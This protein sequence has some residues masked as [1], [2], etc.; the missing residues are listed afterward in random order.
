MEVAALN[1]WI[2]GNV[3]L[4]MLAFARIGTA[5]IMMPG[6]GDMKIPARVKIAF[7]VLL[8]LIAFQALPMPEAPDRLGVL[9]ALIIIEIIIGAYIGLAGRVFFTVFHLI[10]A[11]I[12]FASGLSNAMAP[13]DAN[14]D[15]ANTVAAM[16]HVA[17]LALMFL[18][19]THH[20]MI[21]GI[22]KSYEIIPPGRL[23]LDDLVE[24]FARIT[25][26]S[27]HIAAA[28]GA[29]FIIFAVLV[30]LALGLAN[31]VMPAMQVFFVA[32]PGLIFL[33]LGL[34][35]LLIPAILSGVLVEMANWYLD[36]VR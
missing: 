14:F 11:Q 34:L 5:L 35:A 8:T 29:P 30:N 36:L 28:I 6:L 22:M 23:V 16:M 2:A 21:G 15:G 9:A 13:P 32:G 19:D 7:G 31:R 25:A 12:G 27:F 3:T 18:T 4:L 26:A 17:G 1:A 33:G 20:I 10:G 24:Q